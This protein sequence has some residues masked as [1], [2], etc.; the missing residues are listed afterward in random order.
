MILPESFSKN[1][2]SLLGNDY[3]RYIDSLSEKPKR[4][5][6][7]NKNCIDSGEVFDKFFNYDNKKLQGFD[8]LRE[9]LVDDKIGNS[10]YHHAGMIY[11]QEPSSMLA[12]ES[13]QPQNGDNV[14]DMCSAPGGKAG[15]ILEKDKTGVVVCNEIVRQRANIL[16]SNIERQGFKNAIITSKKPEELSEIF[17]DYFDKI[18]VDAPC[19]GEGMFRKDPETINEWNEGLPIF[20]H[21][22]QLSIL[23]EADKMLKEGGVLVYSTCTFNLV[24]NEYVVDKFSKTFNYTILPVHK[25]VLPF[26][27]NGQTVNNNNDLFFIVSKI[28]FIFFS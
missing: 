7:I 26:T 4:G 23:K 9:L 1:M 16:F 27:V 8:N 19:S 24:E 3:P 25:D 15:Q 11:I 6:R 22:R 10:V 2:Q 5:F 14:L 13:L 20:N 28:F 18:L 21:E 17:V 12:V